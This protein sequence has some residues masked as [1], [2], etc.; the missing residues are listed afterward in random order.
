MAGSLHVIREEMI[1]DVMT[2]E[3][4]GHIFRLR[5]ERSWS[6]NRSLRDTGRQCDHGRRGGTSNDDLGTI[7]EVRPEPGEGSVM[8]VEAPLKN[9]DHYV[10]VN[11][12]ERRRHIQQHESSDLSAVDDVYHVVVETHKC[13]LGRMLSSVGRL[14][15]RKERVPVCV[16]D[17]PRVDETLDHLR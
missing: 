17:E 3:Y 9:I 15:P 10:V 16:S 5:H 14:K 2:V 6:E 8:D 12:V 4:V 7:G 11:G 13:S 1:G